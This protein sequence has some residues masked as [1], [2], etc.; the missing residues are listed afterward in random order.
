MFKAIFLNKTDEGLHCELTELSEADLMEGDVTV[1]VEYST[2]NYKDGL[3]ITGKAPVVRHWPMV[4]GIDFGGE[5][6]DS[7]HDD[8][9]VMMNV[10]RL[11]AKSRRFNGKNLAISTRTRE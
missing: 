9:S 10:A 6:I 2:L 5:V 11:P 3:A 4:P 1:K 7:D 8:T